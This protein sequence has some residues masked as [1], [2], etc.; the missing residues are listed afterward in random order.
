MLSAVEL[1]ALLGFAVGAAMFLGCVLVFVVIQY[2]SKAVLSATQYFSSGI[3]IAVIGQELLPDLK[4]AADG[5]EGSLAIL[6]GFAAGVILMYGVEHISG[7]DEEAHATSDIMVQA[8]SIT[9]DPRSV[10]VAAP[11][12][13]YLSEA[14]ASIGTPSWRRQTSPRRP[15][16][17]NLI[18]ASRSTGM[19]RLKKVPWGLTFPI[20]I[21]VVMDGMLIGLMSA[22]SGHGAVM[23]A[24]ATAVEMGFLGI[25]FGALVMHTGFLKWVLAALLPLGLTASGV[26]GAAS[27][28]ALAPI[29]EVGITS[30]GIAALL[31]LACNELLKE[32]TENMDGATSMWQSG[33]L[34]IGFVAIVMLERLFPE[35][36]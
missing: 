4:K 8:N 2:Q 19:D 14:G 26:A 33:W 17:S 3:L 36:M 24:A 20:Y 5:L 27:A 32:A 13:P 28:T 30:F 16:A 6:T 35:E 22:T 1:G 7:S 25:T 11:R 15:A 10:N 9:T 23:L 12:S 18:V 34:F 21:D 29:F 31:F